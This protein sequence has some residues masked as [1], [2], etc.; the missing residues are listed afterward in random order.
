MRDGFERAG[1]A[2]IVAIAQPQNRASVRV[3]EKF[4]MQY[5]KTMKRKG[6][7]VV[8]YATSAVQQS[9]SSAPD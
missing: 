6:F 8:L 5:E 1:L 2:R 7:D 9:S 4:G 3:M